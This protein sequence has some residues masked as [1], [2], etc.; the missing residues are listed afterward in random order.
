MASKKGKRKGM[1]VVSDDTYPEAVASEFQNTGETVPPQDPDEDIFNPD[2]VDATPFIDAWKAAEA[3]LIAAKLAYDDAEQAVSDA[4]H[5]MADKI[6]AG[7]FMLGGRTVTITSR[8]YADRK[9]SD[10]Q[11][12]V[13]Y[14]FKRI[15]NAVRDLG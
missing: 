8:T 7:P 9:G 15:G 6:G 3:A 11:P 1:T 2:E 13:R 5:T 4:L 14:F 10:G 12:L